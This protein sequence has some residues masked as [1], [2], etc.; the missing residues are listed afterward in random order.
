MESRF[1]QDFSDVRVHTDAQANESAKSLGATAYTTGNDVVFA[2]GKYEPGTGEGQQRIAHELAHVIQQRQSGLTSSRSTELSSPRDASEREADAVGRK[3]AGGMHAPA[4]VAAGVGIQ[5][6]NGKIPVL[7]DFE[8]K[9]PDA[10][11]LIRKQPSAMTLVNE[12]DTAGAQFG[13]FVEDGPASVV[14]TGRA[15]TVGS[16][17]YIPKTR[18]ADAVMAMSDFL[19]EL[20]NAVRKPKFEALDKEATKGS[21][22]TLDAKKYAYKTVELEVE[23]MLRLGKIWFEI[24]KTMPKGA[25]TDAYDPEF[26]LSDYEAVTSGKKSKDD[27]VKDVLKRVYDTGKLKGKTVEQKYIDDYNS[28]SGGK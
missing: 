4:I 27:L 16:K 20:N 3:V 14:A 10:G 19:F 6:T 13:G 26:F 23:G 17:V 18:T 15:C 25:K 11:K 8:K 5:R 7:D 9:F 28:L 12:A 2:A 22:G 24:K 1:S 21:K